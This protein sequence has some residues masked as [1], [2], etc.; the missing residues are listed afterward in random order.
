MG[1]ARDC[2]P[3]PVMARE[4]LTR[5]GYSTAYDGAPGMGCSVELGARRPAPGP[6]HRRPPAGDP[7]VS[8]ANGK[9]FEAKTFF[10]SLFLSRNVVIA[11]LIALNNSTR[12]S[13]TVQKLAYSSSSRTTI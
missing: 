8:T 13:S 3:A 4:D 2:R 6:R 11:S 1:K 10:L 12:S 9:K 5:W 7:W